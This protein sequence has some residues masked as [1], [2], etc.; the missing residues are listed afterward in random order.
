MAVLDKDGE[1]V[2]LDPLHIV[3]LKDL[4]PKR[5]GATKR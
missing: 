2:V 1:I 3:A 5:N 4:P